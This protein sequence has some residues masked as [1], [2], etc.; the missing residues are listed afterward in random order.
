MVIFGLKRE[1]YTTRNFIVR[2]YYKI[3]LRESNIR[4]GRAVES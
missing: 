4:S 3:V 2:T 1:N